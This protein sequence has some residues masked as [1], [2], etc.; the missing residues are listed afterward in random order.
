MKKTPKELEGWTHNLDFTTPCYHRIYEGR[1]QFIRQ[2][3]R[4]RWVLTTLD[5]L[6]N[7]LPSQEGSLKDMISIANSSSAELSP[8]EKK[9]LW[10]EFLKNI[11]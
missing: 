2:Y 6:D 9:D 10:G 1:S 11:T 5:I 7:P 4:T 8:E 3:D